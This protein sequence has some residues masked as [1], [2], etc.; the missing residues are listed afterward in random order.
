MHSISD[1]NLYSLDR[2]RRH[3]ARESLR[4]VR[5][6]NVAR[7]TMLSSGAQH[8]PAEVAGHFRPCCCWW[9][10]LRFNIFGTP[11]LGSCA[12]VLRPVSHL[13]LSLRFPPTRL[14]PRSAVARR[15]VHCEEAF[16][17]PLFLPQKGRFSVLERFALLKPY[18]RYIF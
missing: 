2:C 15:R 4:Q 10:P 6:C 5:L 1:M 18:D 17:S 12:L 14:R 9:S 7:C 11:S 3:T 8:K 13:G 16:L